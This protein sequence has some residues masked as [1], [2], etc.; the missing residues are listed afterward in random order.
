MKVSTEIYTYNV[1][2]CER[3]YINHLGFKV[4]SKA[5]GFV[6]LQ[7]I[8]HPEYELMFCV[9]DSPFVHPAFHPEFN[10]R[11][12]II[13]ME[14]E[15]VEQEYRRMRSKGL[16]IIVDIV[17]EEFNGHHFTIKDPSGLLIDIVNYN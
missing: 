8:K 9:P 7:H 10:G 3:F 17:K 5:E 15:Q 4:K 6:V 14:V 16:E 11:G 13:Q 2:A 1:E 12:V